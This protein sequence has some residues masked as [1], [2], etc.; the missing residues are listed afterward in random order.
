MHYAKL[1]GDVFIQMNVLANH[2]MFITLWLNMETHFKS[3]VLQLVA[4][5]HRNSYF[6]LVWTYALQFSCENFR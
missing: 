2:T 6:F 4:G 1:D 3:F 5:T